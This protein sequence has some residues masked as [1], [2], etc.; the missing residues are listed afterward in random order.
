MIT[1]SVVKRAWATNSS[2]VIQIIQVKGS[3]NPHLELSKNE[4]GATDMTYIYV[5]QSN[6]IISAHNNSCFLLLERCQPE[7]IKPL[8]YCSS[9]FRYLF[10]GKF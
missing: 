7:D 4:D 6:K 1:N 9:L 10:Q 3:S 2:T 5:Y 8:R